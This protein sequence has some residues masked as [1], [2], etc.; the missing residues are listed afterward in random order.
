VAIYGT[1][2]STIVRRFDFLSL[3][4]ILKVKELP[5]V[6]A[7]NEYKGDRG[8]GKYQLNFANGDTKEP[9][10]IFPNRYKNRLLWRIV[11]ILCEDELNLLGLFMT[12]KKCKKMCYVF[13][14]NSKK[15]K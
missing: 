4:E 5:K 8:E 1:S 10:D 15:L 2:L 9:N 11:Y 3:N 14:R 12:D 13:Y 6:I 7:I